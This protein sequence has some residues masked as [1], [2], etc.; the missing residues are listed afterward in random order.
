M[1]SDV[2]F[3]MVFEGEHARAFCFNPASRKLLVR[4]NARLNDV[5]GFAE[6][7]PQNSALEAGFANIWVQA[8]V[9]DYYLNND[10]LELR[11]ALH[12]YTARF[13]YACGVGFSMG[14]FATLLF[15]RAL[16]LQQAVLISPQR[17]G[18][19]ATFPFRSEP[20]V[21]LAQYHHGGDPALDGVSPD[22][23]GMVLFDPFGGRG[24]DRNYA[25]HL[26]V[27]A[28]GLTQVP[29]AGAGHPATGVLHEAKKFWRFQ[30]AVLAIPP[31]PR[32][33]RNIHRNSRKKSDKY[34]IMLEKYLQKRSARLTR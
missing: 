28:P 27:I 24:R 20:D 8:K 29:L 9:N 13:D 23:K 4:F 31:N 21:E 12:A 17:L 2:P 22:L 6:P 14:G 11:K 25:R 33:V 15:S 1:T 7:E 26:A 30:Q 16:R 32:A 34:M 19:P 5:K 10:L 18:F 3:E